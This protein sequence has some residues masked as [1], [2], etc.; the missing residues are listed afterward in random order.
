VM[1]KKSV[2]SMLSMM[3]AFRHAEATGRF[4]DR[5]GKRAVRQTQPPTFLCALLE[6]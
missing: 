4:A 6:S 5:R 3:G 2:A 1:T